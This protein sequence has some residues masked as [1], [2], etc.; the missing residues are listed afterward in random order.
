MYN[1]HHQSL[2]CQSWFLHFLAELT[3]YL[4]SNVQSFSLPSLQLH[5]NVLTFGHIN[6][7]TLKF[8]ST[9]ITAPPSPP[10]ASF[11]SSLVT[12]RFDNIDL[13]V[14]II[15][16]QNSPFSLVSFAFNGIFQLFTAL[17]MIGFLFYF[18]FCP[19]KTLPHPLLPYPSLFIS[20]PRSCRRR[21]PYRT[22]H[23][24]QVTN[25]YQPSVKI[26]WVFNN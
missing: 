22:Q 11:V 15:A 21:H 2:F 6:M 20:F 5:G 19:H 8:V 26:T 9:I 14:I 24:Q 16:P 4:I 13:A 12:L 17:F 25:V 1:F 18:V 3:F 10:F 23:R 7:L